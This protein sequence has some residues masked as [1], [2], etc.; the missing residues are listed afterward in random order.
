M[1][2]R[3]TVISRPWKF[4][5]KSFPTFFG[6]IS[7]STGNLRKYQKSKIVHQIY[8]RKSFEFLPE[9]A[10]FGPKMRFTAMVHHSFPNAVEFPRNDFNIVIPLT[11]WHFKKWRI[12]LFHIPSVSSKR[13]SFQKKLSM[14]AKS[15]IFG[16]AL[17]RN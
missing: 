8:N 6:S 11:T 4:E 13:K 5:L 16:P 10:R 2:S 17:V 1:S 9:N 7:E 12:H 14:W 15:L 3:V